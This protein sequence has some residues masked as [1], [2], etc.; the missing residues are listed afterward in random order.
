[1][2]STYYEGFHHICGAHSAIADAC[3]EGISAIGETGRQRLDDLPDHLGAIEGHF[4]EIQRVVAIARAMGER[5]EAGLE[6]KN[7]RI[8]ELEAKVESLEEELRMAGNRIEELGDR[9]EGHESGAY[10]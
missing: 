8:R 6:R 4:E 7:E 1:M 10:A 3:D 9:L 5:M 2:G